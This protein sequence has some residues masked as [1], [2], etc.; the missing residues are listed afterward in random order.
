[1]CEGKTSVNVDNFINLGLLWGLQVL[2]FMTLE[3]IN[4]PG[5][6]SRGLEPM[7]KEDII[8]LENSQNIQF[9]AHLTNAFYAF[10]CTWSSD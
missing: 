10:P 9:G 6:L 5:V 2:P 8:T 1:M 7:D 3:Q 4:Q